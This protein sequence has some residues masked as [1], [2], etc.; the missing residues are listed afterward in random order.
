MKLD[1]KT[2]RT[3]HRMARRGAD[4]VSNRLSEITGHETLVKNTKVKFVT[5]S[6]IQNEIPSDSENITISVDLAGG[7]GGSSVIMFEQDVA[8]DVTKTVLTLL[9]EGNGK[10]ANKDVNKVDDMVL[11][12]MP[13]STVTEIANIM[14]CGFIDGWADVLDVAIDVSPPEIRSGSTSQ[15]LFGGLENISSEIEL[16]LMFQSEIEIVGKEFSFRHFLFPSIEELEKALSSDREISNGFDYS[17]LV[18]FDEMV[19]EGGKGAASHMEMLTGTDTQVDIRHL[20]FVRVDSIPKELE[21]QSVVGVAFTYDGL[22]SGY[23]LFVFTEDSARRIVRHLLPRPDERDDLLDQ[24]GKDALKEL[25]N[26]MASGVLDGWANVLGTMIDHSPPDYIHD[27]GPA[28][29]D[30][31]A[32][33]VGQNQEYAFVFDTSISA[34][35]ENFDCSIFSISEEGDLETALSK[36]D[37]DNIYKAKEDQTFPLDEMDADGAVEME[38]EGEVNIDDVDVNL[39]E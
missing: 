4:E 2:L 32:A 7:P 8:V 12:E 29:I 33:Q 34:H 10:S 17:K 24:T 30:P 13:R 3:F 39:D 23:L 6:G 27:I 31:I 36:L 37:I 25:G 38:I 28:V 26:I 15:E 20:N 18:G 35:D 22:P 21:G 19:E 11:K 9:E 5:P 1:I 14:N 16:A